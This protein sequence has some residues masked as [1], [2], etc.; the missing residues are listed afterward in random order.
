MPRKKKEGNY[1]KI[2]PYKKIETYK[3]L[4]I[5]DDEINKRIEHLYKNNIWK[6][7][8]NLKNFKQ[9]LKNINETTEIAWLNNIQY[10]DNTS[11][12]KALNNI[13]LKEL[14]Q[15]KYIDKYIENK[16][17]ISPKTDEKYAK[18]I[19]FWTKT[20]EPFKSYQDKDDLMWIVTNN[21]LL[22]YDILNYHNNNNHSISSLNSD[23]KTLVRIIKL[24]LGSEDELRYKYSTLQTGLT[25]IENMGDD[26][27]DIATKQEENQFVLYEDLLA[28]IEELEQSYI[29][30]Y[31]ELNPRTR[32]DP[33]KHPNSLFNIH[34]DILALAIY[35]WDFPSRYEKYGLEF[36]TDIKDVETGKNYIL[37]PKEN[38][39]VKLI[40]NEI[41]KDHKPINYYLEI[42]IPELK[43]LNKRLSELLIKSYKTYPR[44]YLFVGRKN[45]KSQNLRQ[46]EPSTVATWLRNLIP[47]KNI[48]V[49]GLRSAFVS[50]YLNKMNNT[51][52]KITAHRMRTSV[53]IMHRSY[54]KNVYNSLENSAKGQIKIKKELEAKLKT[55]TTNNPIDVNN[56]NNIKVKKEAGI[57]TPEEI[58][59][60]I[61]IKNKQQINKDAW[62]KWYSVPGNKKIHRERVKKSNNPL[63]YA[64]RMVREL[65]ANK[66]SFNSIKPSTIDKYEIK[67]NNE[68]KYYTDLK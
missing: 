47:S 16:K 41:K 6:L 42:D 21:R 64:K 8:D 34:Q 44:K 62:T 19:I 52:R 12:K 51:G 43:D 10:L 9:Y 32:N 7:E 25:D 39:A 5:K 35:V 20:F 1:N 57:E 54:F 38:E 26:L 3:E 56:P 65:N 45:W 15:G 4:Q 67:K 27:N 63:S 2:E 53:D 13:G 24:L 11:N 50:Y 22:M 55:G 29:T 68:G 36:I 60:A 66:I 61:P 46:I 31:N 28:L 40:F 49:D 18:R 33:S 17:K 23:F 48:G 59:Q 30:K 58:Q 14:Q 37:L